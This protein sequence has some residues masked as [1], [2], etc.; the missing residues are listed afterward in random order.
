[1]P[2]S[3]LAAAVV[4]VCMLAGWIWHRSSRERWALETAAPEIARLVD[5]EEYVKAAALTRE[6]RAVLPNDPT[7][8]KLWMRAT[9]E[10]SIASVPAGAE[11]SIR[12]YRGDPNAWETL[13]KTPLQKVRVP[14]DDYVWRIVKPGFAAD[15]LHRRAPWRASTWFPYPAF[16]WNL[17][18]R[19]E[20]SVPPEMVVVPG[21]RV[22]LA[23]PLAH[24]PAAQ[25]DDFLID[26]HEVTNEEYK[27]FVDAGGYQKREFWKQPFVRDG[28]TV[29]WE[30]A[31]ALFHDATGRPGPATWEVG[32]YPKGT[33]NI[34]SPE[35]VGTR[36]RP[37]R[38][39]R[40]RAF[41]RRTTGR[42]RR[43]RRRFTPLITPGSNFRREGTQP[44]GSESALSGFGTTDMAGNVKE[45]C[46]NET[47][48]G[49]RFIL[50]G[51]FGEPNYMFH[52]HGRAIAMGPPS[53]LWFSLR[54]TRLATDR[55]RGGACGGH[56]PRLLERE[57]GLGRCLQGLYGAVCLRQRGTECAGGRNGERWRAGRERR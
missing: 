38:S 23:Y 51:G 19:P 3:L 4:L 10:V 8:E 16:D 37:T 44:V 56:D 57:A 5:A 27:K 30:D 43:N 50:G 39:S 32:D 26:R 54:Q 36:Q 20:G 18:L 45:W 11:V 52:Q 28:R 47:R 15:V 2:G 48:D 46:W 22:G 42:W 7:L 6:A 14:R 31:V 21:G 40:A 25:V 41:P 9:G 17:K 34:R 49:K 1:M 24:A 13:G 29:P 55:C 35:S 33:R 12:P 53:E